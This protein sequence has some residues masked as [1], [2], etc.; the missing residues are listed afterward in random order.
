MGVSHF[1]I[2]DDTYSGR[3]NTLI[4]ETEQTL[5]FTCQFQLQMY[6]VDNQNCFLLFTISGLN[7]DFGL[8]KKVRQNTTTH[9]TCG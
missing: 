8:L 6:P 7:K 2:S 3:N 5:K 1:L 4:M 9:V